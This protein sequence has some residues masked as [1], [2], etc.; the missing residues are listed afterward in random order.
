VSI[1]VVCALSFGFGSINV[2][3]WFTFR[4]K[5]VPRHLLGRV[6]AVTR[7]L[8][9]SSIPVAALLGGVLES[10]LR[11]MYVVLAIGGV[12][13][14][15]VALVASRSPLAATPRPADTVSSP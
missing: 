7:M 10:G 15:A 14:I 8:A 3:S 12:L 2:V 1:S 9:F 11:D 13:R 4:Q 5:I 6:I